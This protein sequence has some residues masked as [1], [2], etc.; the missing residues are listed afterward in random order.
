MTKEQ[1]DYSELAIPP[2]REYRFAERKNKY[3]LMIPTFNEIVYFPSQIEKMKA[4]G[5]F[6]IVDVVVCD[7]GSTDGCADP[8]MLRENGFTALLIREGPGRYST[9]LRM[10][11]GWGIKNGYEGFI[12]V[13]ATDR[14][15]TG[16]MGLFVEKLDEGYD[17]IQGSRWIKGGHAVRTPFTRV[18][19]M[20]LI[21]EPFMSLSARHHLTDIT[22]GYRAYSKRLLLGKDIAA[23]R[24]EFNLH[25]LI[26]YLPSAAGRKGYRLTEV[27]VD[28]IYQ[29]DSAYS[30]HANFSSSWAFL[31]GVFN[32]L[33][34]KYDVK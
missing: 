13:D 7:A 3:C 34:G 11:F 5:V 8:D 12:T 15:D 29:E 27:P 31:K 21:C 19:A 4:R 28:R 17:F 26:Y 2:Y 24:E 23:F 33:F 1:F 30:T 6:D 25:E 10:G 18:V 9:D 20:K 22:N 16:S 14:D 32:T